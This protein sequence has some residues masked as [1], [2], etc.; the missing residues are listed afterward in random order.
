M[1]SFAVEILTAQFMT[2]FKV[3]GQIYHKVGSLL[4]FPDGQHKFLQMYFIG[5]YNDE[6]NARCGISTG[7][8]MSVVAQ[9]QELLHTKNHLA[10][11]FKTAIEMMPSDTHKI[12]IHADKTPAGEHVQRFNARILE[13][14]EIFIVDGQFQP[15][16]I[17]LQRRNDQLT[18]IAEIH[19]CHDAQQ[20][21][22]FSGMVLMDITSMLT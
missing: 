13:E 8:K 7:I 5:D 1:T 20:Y 21:P 18:K 17:V 14:V 10:H 3:K 15:R 9:L 19:R 6:L 4:P 16:D 22:T 2:T 12:V 11:L